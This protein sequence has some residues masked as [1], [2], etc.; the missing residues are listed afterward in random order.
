MQF[1]L[2]ACCVLEFNVSRPDMQL[3][4]QALCLCLQQPDQGLGGIQLRQ[5]LSRSVGCD[6]TFCFQ[7]SNQPSDMKNF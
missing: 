7:P 3:W 4:K 2:Q 5:L 6:S 1:M